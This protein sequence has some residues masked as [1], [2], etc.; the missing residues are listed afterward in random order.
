MNTLV[1]CM[2]AWRIIIMII[3]IY[4]YIYIYI[5]LSGELLVKVHVL[6]SLDCTCLSRLSAAEPIIVRTE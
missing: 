6:W 1:W 4:I 2:D 5:I 3:Y